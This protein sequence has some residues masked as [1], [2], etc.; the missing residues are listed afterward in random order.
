MVGRGSAGDISE[1][2]GEPEDQ[3]EDQIDAG[4]RADDP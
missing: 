2:A 4:H 1:V 3:A